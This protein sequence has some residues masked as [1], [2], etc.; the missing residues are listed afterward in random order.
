[1]ALVPA[2]VAMKQAMVRI[3]DLLELSDMSE[4]E[5]IEGTIEMNLDD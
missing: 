2:S 1:M 5:F 4:P 3:T